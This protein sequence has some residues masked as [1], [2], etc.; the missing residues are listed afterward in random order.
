MVCVSDEGPGIDPQDLPHIFDRFYRSTKA[1]KHTKGAGLGLY[2]TRAHRGS[3]RRSHLGGP[4]TGFRCED[5]FLPA[6]LIPLIRASRR[7]RRCIGMVKSNETE[8]T[9]REF[10][11]FVNQRIGIAYAQQ[12]PAYAAKSIR[13][14]DGM[15]KASSLPM[16]P[17]KRKSNKSSQ[18]FLL[19]KDIRESWLKAPP[20]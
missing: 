18:K 9:L 12:N 2:L 14:S 17:G 10:E 3:A 16:K 8:P 15:P 20:L 13:S 5:L 4:E 1:V 11:P 7:E 19:L 6:A